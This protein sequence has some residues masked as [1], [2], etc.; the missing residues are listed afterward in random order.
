MFFFALVFVSSIYACEKKKKVL[1][2]EKDFLSKK[3][4]SPARKQFFSK[5]ESSWTR[6]K[7]LE[8]EKKFLSK[9]KIWT[10][11][12]GQPDQNHKNHLDSM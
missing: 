8:Q 3:K 6:K 4:T 1:E 2:Q 10:N 9:K 7:F 5:K 11:N 12:K